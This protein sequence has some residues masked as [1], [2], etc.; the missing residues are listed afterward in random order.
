MKTWKNALPWVLLCVSLVAAALIVPLAA[1]ASSVNHNHVWQFEGA[2]NDSGT[3]GADWAQDKYH[4]AFSVNDQRPALVL[5]A[6]TK[7]QFKTLAGVS[8][9][10]C[11]KPGSKSPGNGDTLVAGIKGVFSG[12][13][14]FAVKG[15]KFNPKARFT[16]SMCAAAIKSGVGCVTAFILAVY[17]ASA[18]VDPKGR[19]S[20]EFDYYTPDNG[21]WHNASLD[22]GGNQGD[23]TAFLPAV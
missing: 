13:Y 6:F 20:F 18:T 21:S 8:P 22:E 19:S 1:S 3:C 16:W 7:G 9:G 12:Y 23:I 11:N 4:R 10:A 14:A 2:S 17:G 15:G 5:E